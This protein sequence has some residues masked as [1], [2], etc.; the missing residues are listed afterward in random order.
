MIRSALF[1]LAGL[2]TLSAAPVAVSAQDVPA[3][4]LS[5]SQ[6]ALAKAIRS[7]AR[8]RIE[9]FYARRGYWPLWLEDGRVTPAADAFLS[10]IDSARLDGLRPRDY[11][12]EEL[13]QLVA[14]AGG[15]QIEALA[16][17]EVRLSREFARF[18]AD[19]QRPSREMIYY[20]DAVRPAAMRED[21]VLRRAALASDF[22]RF[23][24]D[25]GWMS[26]YYAGLREA[27]AV[28][29]GQSMPTVI[30]QNGPLL[31]RGD[32]GLRVMQLRR[33]LGVAEG[34][35]FDVRVDDALRAFQKERGLTADGVLGPQTVA[36][37]NSRPR[38][39]DA[40]LL[41]TNLE[42]ARTLPGPWVKHIVVNAAEARLSYF[43]EGK[44]QGSM[45]VVVGTPDTP[46]PMMAGMLS[47]ATLNPYWN[48]PVSLVKKTIAPAV[49]RGISL[50][51]MGYEVMSDWTAN[52]RKVDYKSADWKGAAAG[53][54]EL[55]VRELPG[56]G[57]AMGSV[58]FMFP[59]D[60]G[61]YLHDTDNRSLFAK[62]DRQF[63]NGCVRLENARELGAW[64]FDSRMPSPD[65]DKPEQH[66]PLPTPV[67]VYITY[68]TAV[69]E[70]GG[71]IAVFDDVYNRDPG[72]RVAAR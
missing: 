23:V 54:T 13:R 2:A 4:Q 55:R 53:T 46:T 48:V 26:P 1:A 12:P 9:D 17:A 33:R 68:L 8:G 57:N 69:P 21:E 47:Y 51:D 27:L 65:S 15:G 6:E 25:M 22:P 71:G 18:V 70:N 3:R 62:A 64:L 61:I 19:M 41:R 28:G 39:F 44:R 52:A 14:E 59:N 5:P 29:S 60:Q 50:D 10:Y 7:E 63:S 11:D 42:R 38:S 49:L 67:P 45:N 32:Q 72:V 35:L 36:R 20:D 40:A 58:K 66:I 56:A 16:R 34:D 43:D 24:Q 31:R 30:V 37:L